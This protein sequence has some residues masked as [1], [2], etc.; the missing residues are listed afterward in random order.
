MFPRNKRQHGRGRFA[1]AGRTFVVENDRT[2]N[3]VAE[4]SFEIL[5]AG[6][7]LIAAFH[8][9]ISTHRYTE[10]R[11]DYNEI[12]RRM[13]LA[14]PKRLIIDL[15][16]TTYFGSLFVGMIVKLTISTRNQ[17]GHL[18]LCG[19]SKQL[20][21]LMKQLLLLERDSSIGTRLKHYPTRAEAVTAMTAI[22]T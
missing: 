20:K 11:H 10:F 1:S 13:I 9:E 5:E 14:D 22:N 2:E 19:L 4:Y 17:D 15:T 6:P 16:A 3:S 8:G 21:E 18:A 7:C 12:C